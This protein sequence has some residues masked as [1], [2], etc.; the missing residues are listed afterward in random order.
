M[1]ELILATLIHRFDKKFH[2]V[3]VQEPETNLNFTGYQVPHFIIVLVPYISLLNLCWV[4]KMSISETYG[5]F[6]LGY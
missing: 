3:Q 2:F 6:K 4:I 1:S 5:A